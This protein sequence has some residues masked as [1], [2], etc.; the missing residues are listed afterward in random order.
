MATT[1]SGEPTMHGELI[2]LEPLQ[3]GHLPELYTFLG[4]RL[5]FASGFGGG[6]SAYTESAEAFVSWASEYLPFN[7]GIPFLVRISGGPNTGTAVGTVSII[8]CA[9]NVLG[10][11][12]W[13]GFDPRVWGSGVN[14]ETKLLLLRYMFG[15]GCEKIRVHAD[16]LNLRHEARGNFPVTPRG[17]APVD[18]ASTGEIILM[19]AKQY[20]P[21]DQ[22]YEIGM[23][24]WP[25]LQTM[26]LHRIK[27]QGGLPIQ[28][29]SL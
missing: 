28:M 25:K 20:S 13:S 12:G 15:N 2:S 6:L 23:H 27:Q 10:E 16:N 18:A 17:S 4:D 9:D 7:T 21:N 5:V 8:P 24:E 26:L 19:S 29:S 11:L 1:V 3:R 22:G 14:A